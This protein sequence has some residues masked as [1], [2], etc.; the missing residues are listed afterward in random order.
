MQCAGQQQTFDR[1]VL[2]KNG[3]SKQASQAN[4]LTIVAG[5]L[6]YKSKLVKSITLAECL[7]DFI[8]YLKSFKSKIILIAHNGKVFDSRILVKA[9]IANNMLSELQSVL[10]GFIDTLPMVKTLLPDRSSYKQEELVRGCLNKTYD[11]HNGLE[12]VKSLRDLL[13]HLKPQKSV[14]SLHSFH[15]DFVCASLQH[16]ARM[17]TNFPSFKDMVS[18]KVLSKAM[19]QKIA[20]SGLN[21]QQL[22]LIHARGGYDGLHSVLSAK[23]RGHKG[24]CRVTA[25]KKVLRTLSDHLAKE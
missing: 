9:I 21:L 17:T 25:S 18:K 23:Q 14:L 5:Q 20:G 4:K 11:A 13:L 6:L 16:H 1:Y 8:T 7:Q 2:P 24:K 19:A 22:R 15:V 3:I 10:T 12:D